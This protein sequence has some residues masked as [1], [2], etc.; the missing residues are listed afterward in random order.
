[1]KKVVVIGGGAIGL[2]SAYYLRKAGF[3]VTVLEK[4]APEST[5]MCSFGNAGYICTSHIIALSSPGVI[6]K[7]LKW[8]TN[9]QSP[10]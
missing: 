6:A 5:E 3:E 4:N 7:G 8:L 10:F 2:F 1:M 9:S